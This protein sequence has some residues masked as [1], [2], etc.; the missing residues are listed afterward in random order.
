MKIAFIVNEFPVLSATFIL[1][2]ITGLLDMGHDVRIF[3]YLDPNEPVVHSDIDTFNLR[4]RTRYIPQSPRSKL[5]CLLKALLVIVVNLPRGPRILSRFAGMFLRRKKGLSLGRL[6]LL[7]GFLD[8]DFDII[9]CHYGP[10]GL[11][12]IFLK[13]AGVRAKI[14]TAFHGYDVSRY[15]LDHGRDVYTELFGKGDI[16]MPVSEYWKRELVALGCPGDKI[17]V[18]KMGIDPDKFEYVEHN[19]DTKGTLR[20][21]TVGRLVEKKG[22]CYAIEAMARL[23]KAGRNI[24]YT[25]AGDGPRRGD[26]EQLVGE[27]GLT[28]RVRFLGAVSQ[29][30]VRQ[31]YKESDVFV[32]SSV[33]A[34]DGDMEGVPVVLMEAMA[35]GVVAV[36]T[37][38]SGIGEL[39]ADG[40]T[41][42]VTAER[43][44]T[45]LADKLSNVMDD[46]CLYHTLSVNA[47]R[48]VELEFDIRALNKRIEEVF[49]DLIASSE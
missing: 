30:Q 43:D 26:L 49:T 11:E 22:H 38:Y 8:N 19:I 44:I 23:V 12:G 33:T 2:Q 48:K 6:Y 45:G 1:N 16:F 14:C 34:A 39:I 31:L 41:G 17:V 47:R 35:S 20:V 7:V 15:P 46:P 13:D 4:Q 5:L 36:S 40:K 24:Q 29:T 10:V 25:I 3:A 9:Q 37:R 42:L 21:L 18:H 28:G 27:L 32:L